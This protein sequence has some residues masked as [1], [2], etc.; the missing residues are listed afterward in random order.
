MTQVTQLLLEVQRKTPGSS[1]ELFGILYEELRRLASQQFRRESV[2]HTLQP[3]ALVHEA[4]M[5]LVGA[6]QVHWENR[7]HFFSAA[8]EV[9]RRILIDSARVRRQKKRGG[10][11]SRAFLDDAQDELEPLAE[12]LLDVNDAIAQLESEDSELADIVKLR[13][14]GGLLMEQIAELKGVSKSS[15]ERRWTFAKAWLKA[16]LE[17]EA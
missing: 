16:K 11:L 1:E 12:E 2:G 14:F 5:R 10:D 4:F 3:T 9:M 8:A 7:A 15:I 6:S 17:E 13:F